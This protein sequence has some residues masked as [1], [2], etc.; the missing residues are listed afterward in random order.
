MRLTLLDNQH[1]LQNSG[2]GREAAIE[3][4]R[5]QP[6]RRALPLQPGDVVALGA[7]RLHV[8][9]T[10]LSSFVV[11]ATDEA[12]AHSLME[13]PLLATLTSRM[14][15]R[16]AT[17]TGAPGCTPVSMPGVAVISADAAAPARCAQLLRTG[18]NEVLM[19]AATAGEPQHIC[20]YWMD[21]AARHATLAVAASLLRHLPAEAVCVATAPAGGRRDARRAQALRTLLDARSEAR[22][23]HSL[24]TR[25]EL[26]PGEAPGAL[27]DYLAALAAPLL[28]LG[29][30]DAAAAEST[31]AHLTSRLPAMP[32][33]LVYREERG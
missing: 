32:V 4:T 25:T 33:L 13:A 8:L 21:E 20:M 22:A 12:S 18:A 3:A 31:L 2:N 27:A 10:P 29:A 6:E 28:V 23:A 1:A 26:L 17:C 15:T 11:H 19:L 5:S 24:E 14:K 16:V 30:A 9:P 7:R